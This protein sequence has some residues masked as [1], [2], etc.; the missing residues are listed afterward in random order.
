MK[1]I[2]QAWDVSLLRGMFALLLGFSL[3]FIAEKTA[4]NLI[5]YMGMFWFMTGLTSIGVSR[6]HGEEARW[7]LVAGILGVITGLVA[8]GRPF[9]E[10]IVPQAMVISMIGLASIVTGLLHFVGGFRTHPEHGSHWAQG[11]RLLGVIE[12][13]LGLIALSHPYAAPKVGYWVATAWALG[14]G[15]LLIIQAL[16][17]RVDERSA[18]Q[19]PHED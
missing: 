3:V 12:V 16:R 7:S 5:Q 4:G 13:V 14:A 15:T 18:A 1:R 17:L 11:N 19:H 6:A 8:I 2:T 9:A 10:T